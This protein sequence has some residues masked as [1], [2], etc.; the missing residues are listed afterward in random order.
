MGET[1]AKPCA[2]KERQEVLLP[3]CECYRIL[4]A[5]APQ[6]EEALRAIAEQCDEEIKVRSAGLPESKLR[7]MRVLSL[8]RLP[9]DI[10]RAALPPQGSG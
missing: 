4:N 6:M 2:H 10:A 3:C 7:N 9:R 1:G 8:L 5:R